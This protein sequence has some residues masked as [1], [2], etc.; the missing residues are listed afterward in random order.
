LYEKKG[1]YEYHKPHYHDNQTL[2]QPL[3]MEQMVLNLKLA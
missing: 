3:K 2:K 1:L